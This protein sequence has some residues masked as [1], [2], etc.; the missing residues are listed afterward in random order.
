MYTSSQGD[1]EYRGREGLGI[2]L[3][4]EVRRPLRKC[5]RFNKAT[6]PTVAPAFTSPVDEGSDRNAA[7][8]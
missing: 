2:D 8:P 7:G 4:D 3:P 5:L 6:L 1:N